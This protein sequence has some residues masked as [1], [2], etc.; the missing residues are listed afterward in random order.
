MSG[1]DASARLTF[2][3]S[4]PTDSKI[5]LQKNSHLRSK[6]KNNRNKGS[7]NIGYKTNGTLSGT[8]NQEL[9]FE[10]A[11]SLFFFK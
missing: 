5:A 11:V 7:K 1:S 2:I 6:I 10:S 4:V 9:K 3:K 8:R